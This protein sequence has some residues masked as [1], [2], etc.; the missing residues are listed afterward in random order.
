MRVAL[1]SLCAKLRPARAHAGEEIRIVPEIVAT[2]Q[3]PAPGEPHNLVGERVGELD[4]ALEQLLADVRCA[5]EGRS[6]APLQ[7]SGHTGPTVLLVAGIARHGG[8]RARL[9]QAVPP[10]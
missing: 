1:Q 9:T 2:E 3:A 8:T 7:H 4:E 5:N 10:V 6:G